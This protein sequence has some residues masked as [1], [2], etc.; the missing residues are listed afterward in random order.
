MTWPPISLRFFLMESAAQ[1]RAA[2]VRFGA[3]SVPV[4]DRFQQK[5]RAKRQSSR[6]VEPKKNAA[7]ASA[8]RRVERKN[9]GDA[10]TANNQNLGGSFGDV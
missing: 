2:G 10:A 7:S 9:E 8:L 6:G 5:S 3:G 4:K 1:G